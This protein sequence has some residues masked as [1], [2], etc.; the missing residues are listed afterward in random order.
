MALCI[1]TLLEGD[2]LVGCCSAVKFGW[3][4]PAAV[5]TSVL[6]TAAVAA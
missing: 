2:A 6:T 1:S 5:A 4:V 3:H